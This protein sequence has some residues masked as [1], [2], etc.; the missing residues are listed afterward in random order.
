LVRIFKYFVQHC[1]ICRLS[2]FIASKD[3]RIESRTAATSVGD[4]PNIGHLV[5]PVL[6]IRNVYPGYR[7]RI[8]SIRIT[9]PGSKR[10]RIQDLD[11]H[12]RI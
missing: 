6:R 9:D 10:F 12:N 3:T 1:F 4:I 11:P 2:D 8:F 5:T 7:I